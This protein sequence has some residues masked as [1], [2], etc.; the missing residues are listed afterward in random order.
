MSDPGGTVLS[1]GEHDQLFKRTFRVPEN[2]AG[3]LRSVLPKAL[4]DVIELDSLELMQSD[5]VSQQLD[6]QFSDALFQARFRGVTGW[7]WLLHEHQSEPDPVMPLRALEY[8]ARS[9]SELLR[10]EPERRSLPPVVCVIVHHSERRWNAPRRLHDMVDG[11]AAMPELRRLVPDFELIVDD[12]APQADEALLARPM[13]TVGKVVLWVLRDGRAIQKLLSRVHTWAAELAKLRKESPRDAGT[14]AR[15]VLSVAGADWFPQVTRVFAE[16]V[17]TMEPIMLTIADA[18]RQE[19]MARGLAEGKAESVLAV[20]EARGLEVSAE[21]RDRISA[22]HDVA[23][24]DRWLRRAV[25][26]A[27]VAELF[28]H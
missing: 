24:L 1:V 21:Q 2:A 4:L 22:C 14:V 17:P 13:S 5:M 7:I 20:L 18:L 11:V 25:T 15:Y 26:V 12:L 6:E 19:G 23:E 9:W 28:S 16:A 8:M 3:E 27:T 10:R